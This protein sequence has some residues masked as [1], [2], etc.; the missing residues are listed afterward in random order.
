[1]S[2][3]SLRLRLGSAAQMRGG[4]PWSSASR[5]GGWRGEDGLPRRPVGAPAP[6]RGLTAPSP[7]QWPGLHHR[8]QR[9]AGG[10][11]LALG[12]AGKDTPDQPSPRVPH[13]LGQGLGLQVPRD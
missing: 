6:A 2:H 7:P 11:R 1:M 4:R 9:Q 5:R 3:R 8:L 13:R 12:P 10:R